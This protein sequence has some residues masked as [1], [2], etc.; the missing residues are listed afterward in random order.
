MPSMAEIRSTM[1]VPRFQPAGNGHAPP[2]DPL[3]EA[4]AQRRQLL[5]ARLLDDTAEQVSARAQLDARRLDVEARELE[6]KEEL[7]TARLAETRSARQAAQGTGQG[8]DMLG[9]IVQLMLDE[10]AAA[11]EATTTMLEA[12]RTMW[13]QALDAARAPAT[14]PDGVLPSVVDRLGELKALLSVVQE[15]QPPSPPAA[16]GLS[17][18][19]QIQLE[20]VRL[21]IDQQRAELSERSALRL[22]ELTSR[23]EQTR[24]DMAVRLRQAE[25]ET[26]RNQ[27]FG[28]LIERLGPAA[29][30]AFTSRM[31]AGAQGGAA[32]EPNGHDPAAM[33]PQPDL[34]RRAC[35]ACGD[36]YLVA[37][38]AQA[39]ACPHC[40]VYQDLRSGQ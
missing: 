12:Q 40:H 24:A 26:D 11:R 35:T 4:M 21:E 22:R 33:P 19:D 6:L 39:A 8:G 31:G 10:R 36:E 20:R 29:I 3:A 27:K 30:A 13:Q 28:D 5:G 25:V 2:G 15:F 18:H 34:I 37:A 32:P 16:P 38:E 23:E 14:A 7:L 17:G 1:G 9:A